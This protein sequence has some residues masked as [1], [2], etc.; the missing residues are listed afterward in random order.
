[1]GSGCDGLEHVAELVPLLTWVP[2][3]WTCGRMLSLKG[4]TFSDMRVGFLQEQS[5]EDDVCQNKTIGIQGTFYLQV[6]KAESTA[7]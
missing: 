2:V 7:H 1:M 6:A 5:R 3:S 4:F